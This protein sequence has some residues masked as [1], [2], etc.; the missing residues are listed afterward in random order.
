M[1]S[2]IMKLNYRLETHRLPSINTVI[3]PIQREEIHDFME[4]D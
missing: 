3:E 1:T 4:L 2:L